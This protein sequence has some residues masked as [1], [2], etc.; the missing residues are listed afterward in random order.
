LHG[1]VDVRLRVLVAEALGDD[2]DPQPAG[3]F[4]QRGDEPVRHHRP[5]AAVEPVL[6]RHHLEQERVVGDGRRHRAE[7]VEHGLDDH[8]P[9]VGF[10]P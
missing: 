7:V 5:L 10:I 2:A 9:Y 4:A 1:L 3:G 6:P 8:R